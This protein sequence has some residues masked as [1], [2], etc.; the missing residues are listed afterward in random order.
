MR[1]ISARFS[2]GVARGPK[3]SDAGSP[4]TR[5]TIAYIASMTTKMIRTARPMRLM[6]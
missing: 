2:S 1:S 5:N 4:G 3:A 6:A